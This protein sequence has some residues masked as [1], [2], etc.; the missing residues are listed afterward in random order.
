[1]K[2]IFVSLF[3]LVLAACAQDSYRLKID[4]N[5]SGDHGKS[6]YFRSNLRS[7]YA[8]Q[9][10]RVL[11]NKF[12]EVG[13]KTSASA[14][15][16][17]FIAIFDIETFYK[18]RQAYKNTTYANT[19]SDSALFTAEEEGTS[20]AYTGNANMVV[21]RDKTCFTLNIGRR[22]TS[23]PRYT[24]SFCAQTVMEAEDML[25]LILDIYGKYGNYQSADVGVQC[26]TDQ[27]GKISCDTV[28]D[29]QQAFINSLW[30]D[31][32]ISDDEY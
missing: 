12:G 9:I 14:E 24:S 27:N 26:L 10:R 2:K 4:N 11:S 19:Q 3:C 20:L 6:I 5:M 31:S 15:S 18:Q 21:D 13:M 7:N 29:R 23:T 17:D 25:P 8:G 1:M 30:I 32:D 16:A 28:H 22:E